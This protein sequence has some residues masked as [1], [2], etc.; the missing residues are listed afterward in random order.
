MS[1]YL[2][3][4][5]QSATFHYSIDL[6]DLVQQIFFVLVEVGRIHPDQQ[7]IVVQYRLQIIIDR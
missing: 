2:L 4:I 7:N 6:F 5:Q 3:I 1:Q